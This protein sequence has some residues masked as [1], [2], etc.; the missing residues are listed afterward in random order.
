MKALLIVMAV[1]EL[2]TGVALCIAPSVAISFL[3]N[4]SIG[5]DGGILVG[6]IAGIALVTLGLACWLSRNVAGTSLVMVRAMIIYNLGVAAF[7]I[8]G[9]LAE[10][11]S[12]IGLW[13]VVF[14][15]IVL[16]IWCITNL[17][18]K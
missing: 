12:G 7:F 16:G 6:R 5:E 10:H 11:I 1:G 13:P 14:L 18:R 3:L 4:T 2:L 9:N 8:Y 15:H 17:V